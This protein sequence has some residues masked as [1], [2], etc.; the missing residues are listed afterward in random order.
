VIDREPV[1]LQPP[2][3]TSEAT[4]NPRQAIFV[5]ERD[6]KGTAASEQLFVNTHGVA[7]DVIAFLKKLSWYVN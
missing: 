2:I 5:N 7:V 1:M 3:L 4:F 6:T